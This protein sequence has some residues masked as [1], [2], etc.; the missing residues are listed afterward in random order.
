MTD[1]T[2]PSAEGKTVAAYL[3]TEGLA[4]ARELISKG[5][6]EQLN[7][8]V[9]ILKHVPERA[10]ASALIT[11]NTKLGE[12]ASLKEKERKAVEKRRTRHIAAIVAL[13][14][15]VICTPFAI[16]AIG[17]QVALSGRLKPDASE[18]PVKISY[19]GRYF[20]NLCDSYIDEALNGKELRVNEL[21]ALLEDSYDGHKDTSDAIFKT[22][23]PSVYNEANERDGGKGC[24]VYY[25]TTGN[26]N[27]G[28]K[29]LAVE[30][31]KYSL[32]VTGTLMTPGF[33]YLGQITYTLDLYFGVPSKN[34]VTV[35]NA[36]VTSLTWE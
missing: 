26:K 16:G 20:E 1:N 4:K 27:N 30:N 8:A 11:A 14:V 17:D 15:A 5:G 36:K 23:F 31:N 32:Q 34:K 9:Y 33:T 3:E 35:A 13:A 18:N 12:L 24:Y 29:K 25:L 7:R 21:E 6:E 10:S 22:I 28:V 2:I 19:D